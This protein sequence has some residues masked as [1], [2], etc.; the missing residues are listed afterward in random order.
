MTVTTTVTAFN[1]KVLSLV[2]AVQQEQ[3]NELLS[4][5]NTE[6]YTN[7]PLFSCLCFL[8]SGNWILVL[9]VY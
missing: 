5:T 2:R 8:I 4:L 9:C 7:M 1:N 3:N 6:V